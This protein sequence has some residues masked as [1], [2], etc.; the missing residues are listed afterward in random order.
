MSQRTVYFNGR[1]VPESEA[2]LPLYDGAVIA[3][4]AVFEV[5]RTFAHRPFRLR[6]HLERLA[7]G[8]ETLGIETPETLDELEQITLE[9]LR[10]NLSTEPEDVDWQILQ[11]ISRGPA[12]G[13]HQAFAEEEIRPT[14]LI[15]CFPL[16]SKLGSL[17]DKFQTGVDLVVPSQRAIPPDL[18]PTHVKTRGRLHYLLASLQTASARPGR[19]PVLLDPKGHL[20]EGPT[21][22]F[23][24]VRHGVLR[25]CPA[26]DVLVGVTRGFVL[27]IAH[28]LG[29]PVDENAL[30]QDDALA[31]EEMF[32]T[33]TSFGVIHGRS[34]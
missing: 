21:F 6:S 3:G 11:N 26:E 29:I 8:L 33:A 24:L 15:A 20:T 23:F 14:I 4:E 25:T 30:T 5:T 28:R 10:R 31:A 34:F 32:A 18:L 19:W 1:F 16:I 12:R 7:G 17:A 13:F 2:R 9:T 27:E 22:N